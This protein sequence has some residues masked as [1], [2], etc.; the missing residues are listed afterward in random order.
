MPLTDHPPSQE[1]TRRGFFEAAIHGMMGLI[2]LALA[3]P[4]A[5]YLLT[6]AKLR[7]TEAWADAGDIARLEPNSPVELVFKRRRFDGWREVVEKGTAWVV[8]R[9]D[10]KVIAFGPSCTHLGCAYHWDAQNKDFLCP[11][12]TSIFSIDGK[13][14]SGPAPRPLDRFDTKTEGTRLLIG[15]L[16]RSSG[17]QA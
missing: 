1:S 6:P 5:I 7:K 17:S 16:K 13:V 15:E 4:A 12:H 9:N 14:V 11:C 10:S 8:K 2:S 3:A